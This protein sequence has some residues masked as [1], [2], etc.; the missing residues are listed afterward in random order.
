MMER[1]LASVLALC[2]LLS[3]VAAQSRHTHYE[4]GATEM[5]RYIE[6]FTI[7]TISTLYPGPGNLP[8]D[9]D[10]TVAVAADPV[11][12]GS[13]GLDTAAVEETVR[14][15]ISSSLHIYVCIQVRASITAAKS[16]YV[17]VTE[18]TFATMTPWSAQ[19]GSGGG[20]STGNVTDPITEDIDLGRYSL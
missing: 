13:K 10:I 6:I 3:L 4:S 8:T 7:S 9:T 11:W 20:N 18:V 17:E 2:T 16:W 19:A 12:L 14:G 5:C 1:F 15:F